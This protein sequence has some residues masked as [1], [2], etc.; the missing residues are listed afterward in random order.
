MGWRGL[1]SDPRTDIAGRTTDLPAFKIGKAL[2][3]GAKGPSR[4]FTQNFHEDQKYA[5]GENQWA[6]P[7]SF[8]A[9]RR[10]KWKNQSVR[11]YTF[12]TI[13]HKMAVCLDAE[14]TLR[15]EPLVENISIDD[16]ERTVTAVRHELE[17]LQWMD[18]SHDV[19]FDGA[20]LGKGV[21]HVYPMKDDFTGMYSLHMELVDPT[22][23]YPDPSKTRIR[24]CS[25]VVYEPELTMAECRRIFPESWKLITPK[26]INI[27]RMNHDVNNR[28]SDE[29][30][31][32]P[33]MGET[34]ITRDGIIQ[35]RVADV[36]FVWIKSKEV[37]EDVKSVLMKPPQPGFKC[38]TCGYEFGDEEAIRDTMNPDRPACPMCEMNEVEK[39]MLPPEF[40]QQTERQRAYPY[41]RLIA[42]T[43]NA[44]LSDG[45]SEYQLRGVFP[46]AEY[47]HYRITRRF[48][49]YGDVA[50]LKKVQEALNK[51]V[52]QGI[53]NLRLAG[54]APLEVPAEV[55]AYRQ[56]GNQPGDQIPCPAPFMGLARYLPTNSYNVQLHQILDTALKSDIQ[57]V[58]GVSDVARG[59]APQAPTS[60][61]EV[62]AREAA[63]SKGLGLHLKELNEFQSEVANLVHQMGRVFYT[64]PRAVQK[65]NEMGEMD[66]VVEEWST[67]PP[68][69]I[70]RVS[71]D[72]DKT[73]KDNLLGQNVNQFVMAGGLDSPYADL[74]LRLVAKGDRALVSEFVQR[75][76]QLQA[77]QAAQAKAAAAMGG[78]LGAA[79]PGAVSPETGVPP[80]MAPEGVPNGIG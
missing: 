65:I 39:I 32:G 23:F 75:R 48:W 74:L 22:R 47:N 30:I 1:E 17:R 24:D 73:E 67:L 59:I 79:P 61:R 11:N 40:E 15:A 80:E 25:Y 38:A 58:S 33:G 41:G 3:D 62:M 70:L 12:A 66:V 78:G 7:S 13:R 54:N 72:I 50:L 46:F 77:A 53:D 21:V 56:L 4:N 51:N 55:P 20:C 9:M 76:Q 71:A 57:E 31:Y 14:P 64:E 2:W 35:S 6:T 29:L 28:S 34:F 43:D 10:S 60:G 45:Q 27:G 8:L 52:A 63:A 16:R 49:G 44:L 42:L 69:I 37:I 26:T 68:D 36:A 5:L 19:M 18:Y